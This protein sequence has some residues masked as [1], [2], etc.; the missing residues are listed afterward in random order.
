MQP[1]A[2]YN[3]GFLIIC[4]FANCSICQRH[5]HQKLVQWIYALRRF[6]E[7][8]QRLGSFEQFGE[9]LKTIWCII[10]AIADMVSIEV[11]TNL[12]LLK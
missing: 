10:A 12:S 1:K 8:S 5:M 6:K 2:E 4:V 7:I 3:G 11:M 9:H